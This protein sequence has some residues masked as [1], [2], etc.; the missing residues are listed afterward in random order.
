M[1][2]ISAYTKKG[3][4]ARFKGSL[5]CVAVNCFE[6]FL[7]GRAERCESEAKNGKVTKNKKTNGSGAFFTC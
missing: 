4:S 1:N 6:K 7:D 3:A 2:K 5:F